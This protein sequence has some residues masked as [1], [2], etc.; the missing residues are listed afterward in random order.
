MSCANASRVRV[1][2]GRSDTDVPAVSPPDVSPGERVRPGRQAVKR[3]R[4]R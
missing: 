1:Y 3:L 2:Y 4:G